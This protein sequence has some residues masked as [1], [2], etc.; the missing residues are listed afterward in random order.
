MLGLHCAA[1]LGLAVAPQA[2][3]RLKSGCRSSR[4]PFGM[5]STRVE[6]RYASNRGHWQNRV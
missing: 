1:P 6:M 5:R 4:A 3:L 2:G